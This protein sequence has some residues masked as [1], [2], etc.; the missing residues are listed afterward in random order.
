MG[1]VM[2]SCEGQPHRCWLLG[3]KRGPWG[4]AIED[5]SERDG[6][7]WVGNGEYASQVNYCPVCGEKAP[8][9]VG[10]AHG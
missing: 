1:D 9:Q 5:C 7:F 3:A 8:V 6:E 10:A 2:V 4:V